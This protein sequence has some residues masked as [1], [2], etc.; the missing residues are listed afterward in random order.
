MAKKT[1]KKT[2]KK[3]TTKKKPPAKKSAPQRPR[4]EARYAVG[5]GPN[6]KLESARARL[7]AHALTMPGAYE[8]FP[9]GESVAKVSKKIFLFLGSSEAGGMSEGVIGFGVK[10]PESGPDV[11][12]LPFTEPS[13]YGL[14]K[15]GW[16]TVRFPP[17]EGEPPWDQFFAWI[18][19]SYR[20]VAP[21]KLAA[22]AP[23]K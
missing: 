4:S 20:S 2:A 13:G 7:L 21:K 1:A 11:L 14:G 9:W 22:I 16:V 18:E 3:K 19:E 12:E 10:L 8:D 15:S 5:R 6:K 23:R 17:E